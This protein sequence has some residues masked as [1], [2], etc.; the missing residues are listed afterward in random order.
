MILGIC[1]AGGLGHEVLE[2]AKQINLINNRWTSYYFV[3]TEQYIQ[4]N[5]TQVCGIDVNTF[6]M[7]ITQYSRTDIEF[8]IGVGEPAIRE[9]IANEII[10][11]GY[12][13]ATL[14]HPNVHIPDSANI[15]DGT[16]I[17]SNAFVSCD[18]NIGQ[19]A[20]IQ[21]SASIGHDVTIGDNS[22]ISTFVNF[23]GACQV[24]CNTF[25]GMSTCIKEKVKIGSHSIVSLGSV[26][27]RDIPDGVIAVGNPARPMKKNDEM[28]VF[29]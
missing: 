16:V 10:S 28:R 25:V 19:N 14:I 3:E 15:G 7:L 6:D 9:K 27:I 17:N 4:N 29:R 12:Q 1:G 24:G 5:S 2:L 20:Y 8:V 13:L 11:E 21:Q 23:S 22:V 26:V 18:V